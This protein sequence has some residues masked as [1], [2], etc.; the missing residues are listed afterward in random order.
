MYVGLAVGENPPKR[1]YIRLANDFLQL[2]THLMVQNFIEDTKWW[3]KEM[4]KIISVTFRRRHL[5][6]LSQRENS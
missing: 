5:L 2:V 6:Q 4:T 1:V 3:R